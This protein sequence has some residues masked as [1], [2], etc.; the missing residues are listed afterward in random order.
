MDVAVIKEYCTRCNAKIAL[1]GKL[2]QKE[3]GKERGFQPQ[4]SSQFVLNIYRTSDG[5]VSRLTFESGGHKS[6]YGSY[7][8]LAEE[9]A[10]A[11]TK[12]LT[13]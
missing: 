12:V 11:L 7:S 3:T 10:S 9:I 13:K 2:S 5:R 4:K 6:L 8:A 1:F